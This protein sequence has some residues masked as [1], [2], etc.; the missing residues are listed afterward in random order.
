MLNNEARACLE[1]APFFYIVS[2][3]VKQYEL[4]API[5]TPAPIPDSIFDK[6]RQLDFDV[7]VCL[8]TI[9]VGEWEQHFAFVF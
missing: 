3:D 2:F 4:N 7:L 5:P 1:N 8:L 6:Y 9:F